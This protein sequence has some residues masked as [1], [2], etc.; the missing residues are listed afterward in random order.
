MVNVI[1]IGTDCSGIEAPIQALQQIRVKFDHEWSCDNDI[2]VLKSIKANY[3]PKI[4]YENILERDHSILPDI[5][6]YVCGFPCQPFSLAGLKLGDQDSRSNIMGHC[7][8]VIN[9]K[10]P[11]VFILENVKNFK[12][13]QGGKMFEHLIDSLKNIKLKNKP[14]YNIHFE[15]LNTKD[16]GIP[17]NRERIFFIG[18]RK[19][20]KIKEYKTP[21]K[22]KA[23][24][25]DEFIT[26][27]KI[28]NITCNKAGKKIIDKFNLSQTDNNIVACSGFGNYMKDMSPT[29]TCSTVYYSTKYKRYL[30]SD[31]Y[32]MLQGFKKFKKV[33]SETTLKKQAGNSMSVCVLKAIFKE[34]FSDISD[35][36][37]LSKLN[38]IS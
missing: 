15:V 5:D 2:E 25:L 30:S 31:D 3:K 28:Y 14:L 38:K 1:K 27:K 12:Y 20:S 22:I 33:V 6:L 37:R 23:K 24:N 35:T 26:D 36:S 29:L 16:Y 9:L 7:I 11:K 17:Q 18:I 8:E 34:I 32:L 19:D 13:M 10:K 4:I 21:R